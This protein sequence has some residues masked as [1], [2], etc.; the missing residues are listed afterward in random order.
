MISIL[1]LAASPAAFVLAAGSDQT[2]D[3]N[4]G[5]GGLN[6]FLIGGGGASVVAALIYVGKLVLDRA[7]PSRSDARAAGQQTLNGFSEMVKVL[8]DEKKEDAKRLL[9]KQNRIDALEES[10]EKD[11][12]KIRDLRNDI[13][14]LSQRLAMKDRHIRILVL[15]LRKLGAVV[16]GL[17]ETDAEEE[18]NVTLNAEQLQ[19]IRDAATDPGTAAVDSNG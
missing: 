2:V 18:I 17:D 9:D 12:D 4:S 3:V 16:T 13:L 7:I 14:D 19:S 5:G 1:L 11:Y 10:A 8:Q 15:E 6:T